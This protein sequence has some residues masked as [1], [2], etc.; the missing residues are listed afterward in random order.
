[1]ENHYRQYWRQHPKSV[2][3]DITQSWKSPCCAITKQSK[4]EDQILVSTQGHSVRY[5]SIVTQR[6]E[7]KRVPRFNR[8]RDVE[9]RE[10]I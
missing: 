10:P 7:S 4:I 1:M 2:E 8:H 5:K 3:F 9:I 6:Y